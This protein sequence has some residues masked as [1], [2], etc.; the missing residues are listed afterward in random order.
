MNQQE[1]DEMAEEQVTRRFA[2]HEISV[3]SPGE[4]IGDPGKD[5]TTLH[6]LQAERLEQYAADVA[7]RC[8][9]CGERVDFIQRKI[10]KTGNVYGVCPK[11]R[12][13]QGK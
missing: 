5:C 7:G 13:M 8:V 4:R 3:M 6:P 1:V 2:M 12:T 11:C 9:E 10:E